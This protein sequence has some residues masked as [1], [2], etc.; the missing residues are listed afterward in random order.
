MAVYGFHNLKIEVDNSGGSPVDLSQYITSI[1]TIDKEAVSEESHTAGDSWVEHLFVGLSRM[2]DV[3]LGGFYDDTASTGPD[4]VLNAIGATRTLTVTYGSTKT[5]SVEALI[6]NYRR[7]PARGE[8]TKF[9]AVLR[10]T[11]AVTEN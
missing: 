1:G 8:L 3:T 11:G 7:S 4:A 6:A 9:E 5:T 2:A 10:P